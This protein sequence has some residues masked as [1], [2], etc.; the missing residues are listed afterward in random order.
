MASVQS[1]GEFGP[2]GTNFPDVDD[3]LGVGE[4]VGAVGVE[5]EGLSAVVARGDELTVV[6]SGTIGEGDAHAAT[7]EVDEL[8]HDIS[9]HGSVPPGP[10]RLERTETGPSTVRPVET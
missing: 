8:G 9:S 10:N 1:T 3:V 7:F 4:D 6:E 5:P 2:R